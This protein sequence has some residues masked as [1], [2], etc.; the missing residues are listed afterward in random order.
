MNVE[1][2]GQLVDSIGD[3]VEEMEKAIEKKNFKEANR[4]RT[5]IFDLHSQVAKATRRKDVRRS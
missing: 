1:F 2:V 4:L 5:F 3:A